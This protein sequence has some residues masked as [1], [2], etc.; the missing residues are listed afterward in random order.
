MLQASFS[1]LNAEFDLALTAPPEPSLTRFSTVLS[2]IETNCRQDLGLK[3]ALSLSLPKNRHAFYDRLA[4]KVREVFNAARS[5]FD[6]WNK[7]ALTQVD[8]HLR[9]RR[10]NF[11]RRR[12]V[13]ERV[14]SVTGELAQRIAE[15]E[16][17]D[18]TLERSR[19]HMSELIET[20]QR[21]TQMG[22]MGDEF[23][24]LTASQTIVSQ[25]ESVGYGRLAA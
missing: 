22:L 7:A 19:L 8:S 10:H 12:E 2:L 13:L 3:Q 4:P 9:E 20:I 17:Q 18:S 15:I 25:D 11:N 21:W 16:N 14:H 24:R 6:C 5:E 23:A 1:Q